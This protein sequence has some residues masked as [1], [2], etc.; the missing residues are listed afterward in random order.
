M[1]SGVSNCFALRNW[2][3]L[4]RSSMRCHWMLGLGPIK[5]PLKKPKEFDFEFT[6]FS[7]KKHTMPPSGS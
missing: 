3:R 1:V 6:T 7:S 2:F 5:S 4:F